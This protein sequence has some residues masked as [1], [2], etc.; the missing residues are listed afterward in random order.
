MKKIM[1]SLVLLVLLTAPGCGPRATEAGYRSLMA[2]Y[3]GQHIDRLAAAWGPADKTHVF[4]D[5]RRLYSFIRNRKV[6]VD[7][8][9]SPFFGGFGWGS[10]YANDFYG[11][12]YFDNSRRRVREYLCETRVTT[13]RKGQI[14]DISYRGNNCRA[15]PPAAAGRKASGRP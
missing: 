11:G 14:I 12:L 3:Q 8:P 10:Y 2:G 1:L 5:G 6:Y 15:V 9:M 7:A 13:D 4:A